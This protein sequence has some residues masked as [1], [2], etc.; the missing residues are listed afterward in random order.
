MNLAQIKGYT[1]EQLLAVTHLGYHFLME[2]KNDNAK[3]IFEGLNALDPQND[4]YR[5]VLGVIFQK[6]GRLQLSL[7]Q[8][9]AAIT[10][11]PL[12]PYALVNRAE[13]YLA[14][15]YHLQSEEDLTRSLECINFE[16]P[17]LIQK[18]YSLLQIVKNLRHAN[19]K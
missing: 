6:S 17:Q 2:G 14:L 4:Y 1:E 9:T 18:A 12:S 13:I 10:I 11:N 16:N 8:F 19:N 5:R 7:E 15:G 3:I